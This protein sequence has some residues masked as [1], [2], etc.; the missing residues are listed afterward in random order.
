MNKLLLALFLQL[1]KRVPQRAPPSRTL[2]YHSKSNLFPP[3]TILYPKTSLLV[4]RLM[5]HLNHIIQLLIRHARIDADPEGIVHDAVGILETADDAVAFF[6]LT[7]LVEAWVLDEVAG[8]EH[9]GLDAFALD[10][11]HDFLAVDA[12]ATGHEEAEPA[13]VAVCAWFRQD[14]LV[15]DVLQAVLEIVEVVTAALDEAREF[16]ELGAADSGLHVRD[17]QVQAK[18]RI[19]VFVIVAFRQLAVLAVEAMAAVIILTGGTDAITAPVAH[20]AGDLIEQRVARVDSAALSHRHVMWRVEAGR[21]EVTDTARELL[22][23]ID[24]VEGAKRIA[25]VLDEPEVMLVTEIL[26]SLEVKRIAECMRDHDGLRLVRKRRLELR[27]I[28]VVLRDCHI[29]EDRHSAVVDN[30]RDR[31]RETGCHRD[32]LI[33]A[34]DATLAEQR[35]SQRHEG[36]QIGRR[37]RVDDRDILHA[38]ILGQVRFELLDIAARSQPEFQRTVH[39]IAH[40]FMIVDT[41]S[42]RDAVALVIW[43]LLVV[44]ITV[45][46]HQFQDLIVHFLFRHLHSPL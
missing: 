12:F 27:H 11:R 10:V 41:G 18:V 17:V 21:A 45:F 38:E 13:R 15:L 34:A 16:L 39:E 23:A 22:L 42:I 4:H 3:F 24:R 35:R 46:L 14:E 8:K 2:V 25:V 29:D 43:L 1:W 9:A 26:D 20:R 37:T 32:D 28:D 36:Q 33:P 30:R 31:R 5:N 44:R 6:C 19:D 40:L 7:H